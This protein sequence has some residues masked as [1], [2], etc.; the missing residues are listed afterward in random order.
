MR[1]PQERERLILKPHAR[2]LLK[3]RSSRGRQAGK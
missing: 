1:N 2:R 3:Q